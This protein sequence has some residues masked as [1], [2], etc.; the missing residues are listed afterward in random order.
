MAL[1]YRTKS[2]FGYGIVKTRHD[3]TKAISCAIIDAKGE[4][5]PLDI[6]IKHGYNDFEP[7][8]VDVLGSCTILEKKR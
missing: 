6:C 4:Y 8:V 5:Y 7:I 2:K 1:Y 3:L